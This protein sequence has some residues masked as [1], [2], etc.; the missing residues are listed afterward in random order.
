MK[1]MWR[2]VHALIAPTYHDFTPVLTRDDDKGWPLVVRDH[3]LTDLIVL[4]I[5]ILDDT[6]YEFLP[7][8]L[9]LIFYTYR[10]SSYY[11]Y[12]ICSNYTSCS[13]VV[14]TLLSHSTS[15]IIHL[16]TKIEKI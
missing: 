14:L 8:L 9:I 13:F 3:S 11:L 12:R 4:N 6:T 15:C 5:T 16:F 2:L 10:T 7:I 1:D